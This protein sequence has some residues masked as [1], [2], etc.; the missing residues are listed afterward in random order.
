M[1]V[2]RTNLQKKLQIQVNEGTTESPSLK[3]R[4]MGTGYWINPDE[5]VATDAKLYQLGQYFADL[6]AHTL[7]AIKVELKSEMIE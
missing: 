2:V 3:N 4:S 5:T 6:Q 1:S 7:N